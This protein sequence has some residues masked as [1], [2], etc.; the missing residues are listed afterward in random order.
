MKRWIVIF[1]ISSAILTS[2]LSAKAD[3]FDFAV[4][5]NTIDTVVSEVI[6]KKAYS[7]LGH[8]ITITRLP[9]KRALERA[10]SGEYD[11]DVQRIFSV[12]K[13]TRTW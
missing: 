10:N 1:G 4:A 5:A 11:G 6:I 8:Q 7:I 3:T 12:A 9:P 13:A 2:S